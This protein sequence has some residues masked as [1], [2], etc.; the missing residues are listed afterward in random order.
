MAKGKKTGGK[1]FVKG[2][3]RA[4][5]PPQ[6]P[7]I[8]AASN[9]TMA[10]A[11]AA[12]S[13]YLKLSMTELEDVLKSRTIQTMDMWIARIVLLGLKNGDYQ[14][15]NFMFDRL[16]GKVTEKVDLKVVEPTIIEFKDGRKIV[17]GM[18]PKT[19]ED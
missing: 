14:R 10:E 13:K 5:R 2:D 6:P 19:E 12:L 16:I 4:G 8:T 3:P 9:L 11:R 17:M 15:L 1:D 18:T 7:E